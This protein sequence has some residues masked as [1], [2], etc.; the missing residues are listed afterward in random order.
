MCG[1]RAPE[2][3]SP[4]ARDPLPAPP[5]PRHPRKP[6]HTAG[7]AR[8]FRGL[9]TF[10]RAASGTPNPCPL[11]R[12]L[13]TKPNGKGKWG[14]GHRGPAIPSLPL[15]LRAAG[16]GEARRA[17]EGAQG[18]EAAPVEAAGGAG[19]AGTPEPEGTG[20]GEDGG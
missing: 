3:V 6:R 12:C 8:D 17:A 10:G 18:A 16:S 9:G 19:T 11:R 20:R 7:R 14:E 5:P 13:G 2:G 1:E 4:D 15:D